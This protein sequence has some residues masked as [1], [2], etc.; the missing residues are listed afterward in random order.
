MTAKNSAKKVASAKKA[1]A[2]KNK[3]TAS[4]IQSAKPAKISSPIKST[5]VKAVA[6]KASTEQIKVL[7]PVA[8]P[9]N[10]KAGDKIVYPA[11][12]VGEITEVKIKKIGTQDHC[13][14]EINILESGMRCMVP[15]G[16]AEAVGLRKVIDKVTIDKIYKILGQRNV[17]V[18]T[19]TWNRRYREYTQK[20]KT[21][22]VFEMAEVL[23]DLTVLGKGKD[24]S[25]GEKKM[26]DTVRD[27]LVSEIA[28]SKARTQ[29][30]ILGELAD[31]IAA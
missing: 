12:G 18:D 23:R 16:Q 6:V 2:L 13:F 29:D 4:K 5:P 28:I 30:K 25:F 21:G 10:F 19:Q 20:I 31:I 27:L 3:V 7:V 17:K 14:Y 15:T 8:K 11:H 22:S 24:L 9:I 26:F 1:P